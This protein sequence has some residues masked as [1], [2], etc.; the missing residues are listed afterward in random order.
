MHS[1]T[2]GTNESRIH[3]LVQ[4]SHNASDTAEHG[5]AELV[6]SLSELFAIKIVIRSRV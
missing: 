3:V 4:T 5:Q 2:S 6:S 1:S